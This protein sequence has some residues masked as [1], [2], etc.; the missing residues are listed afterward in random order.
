MKIMVVAAHMDDE[1]LGC[2]GTIAQHTA[3]GDEVRVL[4]VCSRAYFNEV[5]EEWIKRE[6]SCAANALRVL[7]VQEHEFLQLRDEQLDHKVIDV[8]KPI[9]ERIV[10]FQPDVLYVNH[11]GDNNQDHRAVFNAVM[12]ATRTMADWVPARILA[13]EVLSSTEQSP[14]F[15]EYA[16]LPTVY[17]CIC[18]Q[19]D[20]KIAAFR[21]YAYEMNPFPHPRS[22]EGIRALAQYRGMACNQSAAE[23]FVLVREIIR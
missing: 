15:P 7:G 23:A 6:E 8:V 3:V 22:P 17:R 10:A 16:F 4:Y 5:R 2:G 1:V 19:L 9:E 11:R 20:I 14:K 13:Y 21:E 18:A 12:I